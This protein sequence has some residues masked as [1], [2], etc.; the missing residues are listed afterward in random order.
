M[1]TPLHSCCY[2]HTGGRF[3]EQEGQALLANIKVNCGE[4]VMATSRLVGQKLSR[5]IYL[6]MTALQPDL[7]LDSTN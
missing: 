4:Q 2:R 3:A 6:H 1:L 5:Q 7:C